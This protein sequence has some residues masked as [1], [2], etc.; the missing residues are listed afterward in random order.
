MPDDLQIIQRIT[1]VCCQRRNRLP[2]IDRRA[3]AKT[4][5]KFSTEFPR[6]YCALT[7]QFNGR[8]GGYAE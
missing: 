5:Y 7:G 4:N 8:L 6:D 2:R 1:G 3:S